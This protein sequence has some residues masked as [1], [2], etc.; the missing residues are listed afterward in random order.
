MLGLFPQSTTHCMLL[1]QFFPQITWPNKALL[2]LPKFRRN[3]AP[4]L[5]NSAQR[6]SSAPYPNLP[7]PISLLSSLP[8]APPLHNSNFTTRTS[9]HYLR[10]FRIVNC[11]PPIMDVKP[12]TTTPAFPF[13]PILFSPSLLFILHSANSCVLSLVSLLSAVTYSPKFQ[14]IVLK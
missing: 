6:N 7:F 8:N 12:R 2:T 9:G 14:T 3:A 4:Q 5:Q 1:T 13:F 10:A 11:F